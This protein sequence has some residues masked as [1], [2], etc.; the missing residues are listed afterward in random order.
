MTLSTLLLLTKGKQ[1]RKYSRVA[2]GISAIKGDEGVACVVC[3]DTASLRETLTCGHT[4]C[5]TCLK[6]FIVLAVEAASFPVVCIGDDNTCHQPNPIPVMRSFLLYQAF[7]S[8]VE[9]AFHVHMDKN[10]HE[11]KYCTIADCKQTYSVGGD[12][13]VQ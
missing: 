8:L 12:V 9:T 3:T 5:K 1:T 2:Q 11:I 10:G 6:H 4:D 7:H 13:D